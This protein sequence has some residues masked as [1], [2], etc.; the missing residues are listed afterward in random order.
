MELKTL[1]KNLLRKYPLVKKRTVKM[2]FLSSCLSTFLKSTFIVKTT[3]NYR[4]IRSCPSVFAAKPFAAYRMPAGSE[5][6]GNE[7]RGLARIHGVLVDPDNGQ[8]FSVVVSDERKSI[9]AFDVD[10][11]DSGGKC[12]QSLRFVTRENLVPNDDFYTDYLLTD[13]DS[14]VVGGKPKCELPPP[15]VLI[16]ELFN[17]DRLPEVEFAPAGDNNDGDDRDD[18][19]SEPDA[20]M[21][22]PM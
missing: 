16:S 17:R 8:Y 5:T 19:S 1:Q 3:E 22:V 18:S 21:L 4:Q 9:F 6:S 20:D 13:D 14:D 2:Y 11:Y 12:E 7:I 15:P 10:T